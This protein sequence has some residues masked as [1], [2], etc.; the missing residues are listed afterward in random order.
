MKTP[1]QPPQQRLDA[2]MARARELRPEYNQ[3]PPGE[4]LRAL[5]LKR[6]HPD[7]LEAADGL[8][9]AVMD[10]PGG[11]QWAQAVVA[12]LTAGGGQ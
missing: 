2:A 8:E 9:L 5:R 7:F 4:M 3:L 10:A 1:D 11:G 12:A 6:H